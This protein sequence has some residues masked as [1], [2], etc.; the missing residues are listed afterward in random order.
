MKKKNCEKPYDGKKS[1]WVPDK[2]NGGYLEGL[3]EN[4]MKVADWETV[5]KKIN[6][7][8]NGKS[9]LILSNPIAI[10]CW[11]VLNQH[12]LQARQRHSSQK[13]YV[14]YD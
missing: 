2:A 6:V 11:D 4:D 8:I 9:S 14:R 7:V 10:A 5:G 12:Q 3:C 13:R 1:A